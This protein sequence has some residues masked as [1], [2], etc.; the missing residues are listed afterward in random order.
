MESDKMIKQKHLNVAKITTEILGLGKT[1]ADI[2]S[3]ISK[4]K[5]MLISD[6]AEKLKKSERSVRKYLKTLV[7]KGL[8]EKK[9]EITRNNR[10]AYKY[11]MRS[12]EKIFEILKIDLASKINKVESL[13]TKYWQSR[14]DRGGA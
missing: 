2:L 10:L 8:L 13:K 11:S 3:V 9:I 5:E 12:P 14:L 6:I 7:D 4:N 1:V